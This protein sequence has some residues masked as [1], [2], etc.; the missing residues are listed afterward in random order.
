MGKNGPRVTT[1]EDYLSIL[2]QKKHFTRRVSQ[3]YNAVGDR[4][5]AEQIMNCASEIMINKDHEYSETWFCKDKW[6]PVCQWKKSREIYAKLI[7]IVERMKD[8]YKFIFLT[9]TV[10]NVSGSELL[11]KSKQMNRAFSQ[12]INRSNGFF[13]D[14]FKGAFR[15]MEVTYNSDRKDFHPHLH[16]I[17]AV[18]KDYFSSGSYVKQ[19]DLLAYWRKIMKDPSI[20]SVS[21]ETIG[22]TKSGF[23][24]RSIEKTVAEVAKYPF[25]DFDLYDLPF[26]EA[27]EVFSVLCECFKGRPVYRFMQDIR[28]IAQQI[29]AEKESNFDFIQLGA[30]DIFYRY[31]FQ[32]SGYC[33]YYVFRGFSQCELKQTVN[34]FTE[35]VS[36]IPSWVPIKRSYDADVSQFY[37]PLCNDFSFDEVDFFEKIKKNKRKKKKGKI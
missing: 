15:T 7:Q 34:P 22:Y 21:M 30:R 29:E 36:K 3:L 20:T 19:E 12:M 26:D 27:L 33:S 5:H 32:G 31:E 4:R 10:P 24:Q 13:R 1:P 17:A 23:K 14:N 11:S 18:S 16:V 25:K 9:F 2:L 37:R 35:S 6:C 28:K 8:D